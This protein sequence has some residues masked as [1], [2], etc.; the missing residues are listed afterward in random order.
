[1]KY[2]CLPVSAAALTGRQ[3]YFTYDQHWTPEGH[4]VVADTVGAF[5][6]ENFAD[7]PVAREAP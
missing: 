6:V 5:L 4:Q 2:T 3:V 1:V 7:A